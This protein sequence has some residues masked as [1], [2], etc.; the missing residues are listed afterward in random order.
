MQGFIPTSHFAELVSCVLYA[1]TNHWVSLLRKAGEAKERETKSL[2][3][4]PGSWTA[5]AVFLLKAA[6]DRVYYFFFK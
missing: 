6:T 1:I 2:M 4:V 5:V 3:N